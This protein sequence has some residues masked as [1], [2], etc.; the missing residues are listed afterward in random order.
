MVWEL[1]TVMFGY[2]GKILEIDLSS[3]QSWEI[4]TEMYARDF[5]GG[6]GIATKLYWERVPAAISAFSPQNCIIFATGPL[7]GFMRL[8]GSRLFVC[9]KSPIRRRHF[10]SY[11]NVGGSWGVWL[12]RTGY[13]ALIVHGSSERPV[14][15]F[16]REG[17]AEIRDAQH[18][19]G[20]SVT[21]VCSI[22][23]KELGRGNK[24]LTIGQAGENLVSFAT[25]CTDDG[26]SGSGGLGSVM[27]SKKLKA[28]VLAGGKWRPE[29]ALPEKLGKLV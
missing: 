5:L 15:I 4:P 27:G 29:V 26:A 25:L 3:R 9:G 23:T 28:I 22:I 24:V 10:F 17:E 19:W 6:R 1:V 18:L 13:D 7:C 2:A 11:A 8:S 14:Y 21:E 20:K 12:K 16:I